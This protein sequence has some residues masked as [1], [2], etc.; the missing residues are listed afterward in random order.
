MMSKGVLALQVSE[1]VAE[2]CF[3]T[4][5]LNFFVGARLFVET[6]ACKF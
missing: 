2:F 3:V 6:L 5:G 4:F 1:T